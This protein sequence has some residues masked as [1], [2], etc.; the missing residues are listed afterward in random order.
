MNYHCPISIPM[1]L[2]MIIH[3]PVIKNHSIILFMI[4]AVMC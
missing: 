3:W 1:V 2:I 4:W